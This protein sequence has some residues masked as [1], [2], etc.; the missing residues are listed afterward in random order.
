MATPTPPTP[1]GD[2]TIQLDQFLKYQGVAQ[3]GGQAKLLIQAGEIQVNGAVETR[4]GR[5][6]VSG[7]RVTAFDQTY[8][9][10]LV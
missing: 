2:R 10:E 4:R 3:T 6:L 5:K 7:D 1:A 9:V 8:T